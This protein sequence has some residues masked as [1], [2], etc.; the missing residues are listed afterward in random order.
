MVGSSQPFLNNMP[1]LIDDIEEAMGFLSEIGRAV[2]G[3]IARHI[4]DTVVTVGR[5]RGWNVVRHSEFAE[6]AQIKLDS[7][8]WIVLDPIMA[9]R[10]LPQATCPLT[11]GRELD[12]GRATILDVDTGGLSSLSETPI[13]L[14]DDAAATGATIERAVSLARARGCETTRIRVCVST[15]L[16]RARMLR[17]AP[18]S[19]IDSFVG[20]DQVAVHLRDAC[21]YLPL[22]GRRV[23]NRPAVPTTHGPVELRLPSA[24]INAGPWQDLYSDFRVTHA[25]IQARHYIAT[26]LSMVLSRDAT[27]EDVAILGKGIGLP[28]YPHQPVEGQTLLSAIA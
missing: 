9:A 15:H 13:G 1:V 19:Q 14:L 11:L 12:N 4:R 21:P 6:W 26:Q 25:A 8:V 24:A 23:R 22:S 18:D 20:G 2:I 10:P 27:V 17:A 7:G 5:A 16:A 3:P 28:A